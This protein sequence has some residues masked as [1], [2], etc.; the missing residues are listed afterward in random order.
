M[1]LRLAAVIFLIS[2]TCAVRGQ[3]AV[4]DGLPPSGDATVPPK[5]GNQSAWVDLRQ[6][7]AG[8]AN[9]QPAPDWVEA[10]NM[11]NGNG[12]DGSAKTI[13]RIRVANPAGD[14]QV[15]YLRIFFDD[16]ENARPEIVAWDE[17]GT[18]LLRSGALGSGT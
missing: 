18:Q 13:F 12:S 5:E 3:E 2:A 1:L 9:P 11:T 8:N 6:Q 4:N 14:F 7:P 15:I 10:V 16:K 17:S